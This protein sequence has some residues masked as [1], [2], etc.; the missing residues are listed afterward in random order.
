[1]LINISVLADPYAEI[2]STMS[3][4][5]ELVFDA[6]ETGQE[7]SLNAFARSEELGY[8][9]GIAES[10]LALGIYY[11]RAGEF[12]QALD[13]L[14][15]AEELQAHLSRGKM[16]AGILA[17]YL[18]EVHENIG[19]V[20]E[21]ERYFSSALNYYEQYDKADREITSRIL[22]GIF[23]GRRGYFEEALAEFTRALEITLDQDTSVSRTRGHLV[24]IYNDLGMLYNLTG[25]HAKAKDFAG[26]SI[27]LAMKEPEGLPPLLNT[28]AQIYEAT[29]RPD[30]AVVYYRQSYYLA[31]KYELS[32]YIAETAQDISRLFSTQLNQADSAQYYLEEALKIAGSLNSIRHTSVL[33]YSLAKFFLEIEDYRKADRHAKDGLP[34]FKEQK[35]YLMLSNSYQILSQVSQQLGQMEEALTFHQLHKA[36]SDSVLMSSNKRSYSNLRVRLET[37]ERQKEIQRLEIELV[38]KRNQNI[39]VIIGAGSLTI[40]LF[41]YWLWIRAENRR[42]EVVLN[43]SRLQQKS[44]EE[45]LRNREQELADHMLHMIRKNKFIDEIEFLAKDNLKSAA[46]QSALSNKLLKSINHNKS[47]D[48]DWDDFS[49]YFGQVH[50]GFFD[51]LKG[52]YPSL[53]KSELRHCALIRM[54][55]TLKEASDIMGVEPSSVKVARYRLKKKLGLGHD[56]DLTKFMTNEF[57]EQG[58]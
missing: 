58:E 8:L 19:D 13:Y 41:F 44:A 7:I 2:D 33:H 37:I 45:K 54:N 28:M 48:R 24:H 52:L 23:Y 57:L 35:D 9:K 17:W 21:A 26:I 27:G 50:S 38:A 29:D 43:Y 53:G 1:M 36:F 4:A 47:A 39:S 32:N 11:I 12:D 30:S 22:F 34:V 49:R 14:F 31:K 10:G 40:L 16:N 25:E 55:M 46:E 51:K 15:R 42:K 3:I 6:P 20:E 56:E 5:Y 18:G